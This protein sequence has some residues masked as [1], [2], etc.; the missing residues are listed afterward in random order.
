MTSWAALTAS[1]DLC[2]TVPSILSIAGP[3][4]PVSLTHDG[5]SGV[6]TFTPQPFTA[7]SNQVNG[8]TVI[9]QCVGGFVN[10]TNPSL[11]RDC[12]VGLNVTGF[13]PGSGWVVDVPSDQTDVT[14]LIPDVIAQV[15]AH[16]DSPGDATFDLS[17]GMDGGD[18]SQ[19][20]PGVYCTTV[21][22]T[23]TAN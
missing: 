9:F 19:L 16:S 21:V 5:T 20:P 1:L 14:A 11:L 17:V 13:D 22:A 6:Q 12:T 4:G 7:L 10:T 15:E 18:A 8:A 3:I 2:V 23:I